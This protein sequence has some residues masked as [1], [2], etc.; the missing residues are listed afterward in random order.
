MEIMENGKE[1]KMSGS[2]KRAKAIKIDVK[3]IVD[4]NPD[5]SFLETTPE[6]HYGKNGSNWEHVSEDDRQEVI[7]NYGSIW[8]ACMVY[9][10]H[11]KERLDAYNRGVWEMIGIIAVAT[12][13]IPAGSDTVKIQTIDSGGLFGIESDSDGSYIQD[14]GREQIAEVKNY[15]RILCVEGVDNCE[16][17]T[18]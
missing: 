15:L 11:D 1:E 6:Y 9:A 8:N 17:I 2:I 4:E 16:I 10:K 3:R 7:T 13:H 12:I 5:L 18:G 14:I